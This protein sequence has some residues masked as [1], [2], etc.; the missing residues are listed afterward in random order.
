M[1][2]LNILID[3]LLNN[4]D[5]PL[6]AYIENVAPNDKFYFDF[7][8]NLNTNLLLSQLKQYSSS[9]NIIQAISIIFHFKSD[10]DITDWVN[11]IDDFIK[12]EKFLPSDRTHHI[13]NTLLNKE[14][15]DILKKIDFINPDYYQII[16]NY[17]LTRNTHQYIQFTSKYLPD[18]PIIL[19]LFESNNPNTIYIY[20]NNYSESKYN[21]LKLL[22]APDF[23]LT[24][25]NGQLNI[26]DDSLKYFFEICPLNISI[27]KSIKKTIGISKLWSFLKFK[28]DIEILSELIETRSDVDFI[29]SLTDIPLPSLNKIIGILKDKYPNLIFLFE[30]T[31][32]HKK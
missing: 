29:I 26:D 22:N 13:F 15:T 16:S 2:H 10:A 9:V 19:K 20:L 18:E 32:I 25:M 27:F 3:H 14:Q 17:L 28:Y 24:T 7:F 1:N 21:D 5:F 23:I 31:P 30:A 4:E 12:F 11:D 8:S 6:W